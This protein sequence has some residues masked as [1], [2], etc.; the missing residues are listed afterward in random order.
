MTAL[1]A[2]VPT[3]GTI[4]Q[5]YDFIVDVATV[6]VAPAEKVYIN[7]PDVVQVNPQFPA[8]L[9]DVTTYANRGQQAQAKVG[10]TPT[11]A[12]NILK[13]RDETGEF[14]PYWLLLKNASDKNGKD[15]LVYLRWYDSLGA[16]DAYEGLFL[17]TRDA[18]PES[19]AQGVG[20]EAFTFTAAGP[21]LPIANPVKANLKTSWTVQVTGT[22][23]G[24]TYQ[25]TLN[26][27]PTADLAY[28]AAAADV[29]TALNALS[30]VTGISGITAA[31]T[32]AITVT[33]PTAATLAKG[34]V[35]LTGGTAP[36]VTVA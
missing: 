17:V 28:D 16:S 12:F 22:P 11:V 15:N 1:D 4:A 36:D 34:T 29:A 33:L 18:R 25:L 32:G 6:P 2:V 14:Q 21:V 31:G 30:G 19:G 5:S 13:V 9:Q 20:W 10:S 24:G 27:T 35:A 23:T 3:V 8:Q 7:V 26:G